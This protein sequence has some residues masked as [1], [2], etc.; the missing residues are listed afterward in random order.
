MRNIINNMN[1][2]GGKVIA[3]GGFGCI[4]KPA[5]KCVDG[6]RIPGNI[7]K[8]MTIKHSNDEYNQIQTFRRVLQNIPNY[9]KYFLVDGFSICEPDKL[10]KDDL[11]KFNKKC[12]TLKKRKIT[13]KNINNNLDKLLAINMPYGGID[14]L[15]YISLY[16]DGRNIIYLNNSLINLLVDGIIPMNNLNCFHGDIKDG[17]ILVKVDND[18]I[19]SR[20]IDWGLAFKYKY[21]KNAIPSKL[22]RRPF[23]FN[24]PFSVIIFNKEFIKKYNHFLTIYT[25]PT[26]FQI[27]EFVINYIFIWREIRGDG[28]FKAINSIMN[29]LFVNDLPSVKK[30]DL[31]IE[32]D[33]TYYYIIEYISKVLVTY[34]IDNKFMMHDYFNNVFLKIL[35]IWGFVMVYISLYEEFYDNYDNL[36]EYQMQFMDKIKYIIIHFLYE[37]PTTEINIPELIAELKKLNTICE[38]FEVNIPSLKNEYLQSCKST[39]HKSKKYKS[40][41]TNKIRTRKNHN[42]TGKIQK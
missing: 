23:Q 33:F 24:V 32:Y 30:Q 42:K 10:T 6:E 14:I 15:K 21:S 4:F 16:H 19:D 12:K 29:K 34:T 31:F 28:H 25:N 37:N 9:H 7:S 41:S 40:I 17:N 3:S 20:L 27:R 22:Y 38:H 5:L 39:T 36:N 11:T 8:L 1:L 26:Y 18:V 35:D 2:K 13:A